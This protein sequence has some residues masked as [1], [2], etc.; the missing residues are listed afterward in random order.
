[1]LASQSPTDLRG[2]F[3]EHAA[4]E[5]QRTDEQHERKKFD[6]KMDHK[7][8]PFVDISLCSINVRIVK[9][10]SFYVLFSI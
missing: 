10:Y 5:R 2:V 3:S 1:M 9:S 8:E 4:N 7:Q 6:A